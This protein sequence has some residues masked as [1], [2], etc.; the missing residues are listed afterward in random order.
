MTPVS[1]EIAARLRKDN[2]FDC[3]DCRVDQITHYADEQFMLLIRSINFSVL[4]EWFF[5]INRE[6]NTYTSHIPTYKSS[7]KLHWT[8]PSSIKPCRNFTRV[9]YPTVWYFK[10]TF[11][12][13]FVFFIFYSFLNYINLGVV[14][15]VWEK[16]QCTHEAQSLK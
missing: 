16:M 1:L 5:N 12:K 8:D 13:L 10:K 7:K 9:P 4:C 14:K 15:A 6:G 2:Y 3:S 11:L